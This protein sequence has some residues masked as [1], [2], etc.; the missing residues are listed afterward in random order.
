LVG[1]KESQCIFGV[2]RAS[3][4]KRARFKKYEAEDFWRKGF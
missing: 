4:A 1:G 2:P 3:R